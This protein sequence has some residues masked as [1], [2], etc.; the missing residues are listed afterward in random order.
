M[1]AEKRPNNHVHVPSI[2]SFHFSLIL[3]FIPFHFISF[4]FILYSFHSISH[5]L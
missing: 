3:S 1:K 5:T 2:L 4:L